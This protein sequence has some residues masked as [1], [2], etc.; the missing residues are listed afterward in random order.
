M[1]KI[2]FY[3][4]PN[5]I[6]VTTDMAGFTTEF[7]KVYQRTIKLYKG[8]DNTLQFEVRSADQQRQNVVGS[9]IVVQFLDST[10]KEVF[11]TTGSAIM[12]MPGML[13]A[14]IPA[15]LM[16]DV[17][18]QDL[19]IVAKLVNIDTE[20]ESILYNDSQFGLSGTCQLL[21]GYD[22][23][24]THQ[25]EAICFNYE[26]D[27]RAYTSEL[28]QVGSGI[29]DVATRDMTVELVGDFL[30][31]IHVE[32]TKDKSTAIGNKWVRLED[33]DLNVDNPT[34]TYSDVDYR[35]VRFIHDGG[36]PG[37][38]ATFNIV[39]NNGVYELV[40]VIIRGQDYRIG[41]QLRILGSQ[42]GGDDGVNDLVITV[43]NV[44]TYP[45]GS[46]NTITGL[47][48]SGTGTGTG[49]FRNVPANKISSFKTVDKIIVRS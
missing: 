45:L 13:Q 22:T 34:K 21:E 29:N 24:P 43:Q 19:S 11:N 32:V 31:T 36:G 25:D 17:S 10:R 48:W 15:A 16:S 30:G 23:V 7:R 5:R 44:N 9:Q 41:D 1:Q 49:Y 6:T 2:Q 37:F 20:A 46:L 12:S 40:N 35:F 28:V 27:K 26:V 38:G 39:L 3:L 42:L 33:W 4:V 47:T 8:I 14:T 18:P